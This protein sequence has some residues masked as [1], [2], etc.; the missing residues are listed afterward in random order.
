MFFG[1]ETLQ[2]FAFALLVGV[3]SGAYSSIFIAAPV[4][5]LW[6]ER[7]PVYVRRRR[8]GHGRLRRRGARRSPTRSLGEATR[9]GDRRAAAPPRPRRTP[10]GAAQPARPPPG[11]RL[12]RR[13]RRLRAEPEPPA[14]GNGAGSGAT[15]RRRRRGGGAASEAARSQA[16]PQEAR[17]ALT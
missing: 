14:D 12:V 2:D 5:T 16:R 10:V 6:K 3:A 13:R 7:E 1:G 15:E 9:A 4:L 8:I 11:L 17:E